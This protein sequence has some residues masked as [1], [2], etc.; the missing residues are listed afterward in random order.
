MLGMCNTLVSRHIIMRKDRMRW[1]NMTEIKPTYTNSMS[2]LPLLLNRIQTAQDRG[3]SCLSS[4]QFKSQYL[5]QRLGN[6]SV[7][8]I[9][10]NWGMHKKWY[11]ID[12]HEMSKDSGLLV[13]MKIVYTIH[14]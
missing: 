9:L 5:K 1:L 10:L 7:Q 6:S 8:W 3:L 14:P 11:V 2:V 4:P 13:R 12:V